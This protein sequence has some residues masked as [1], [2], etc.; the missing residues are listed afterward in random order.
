MEHTIRRYDAHMHSLSKQV[1]QMWN[2]YESE[3]V[4]YSNNPDHKSVIGGLDKENNSLWE[5]IGRASPF[6]YVRDKVKKDNIHIRCKRLIF[7]DFFQYH[8]YVEEF[9]EGKIV[10][11]Q[12]QETTDKKFSQYVREHDMMKHEL[13]KY[14][15]FL[16]SQSENKKSLIASDFDLPA[17]VVGS[18]DKANDFKWKY[19]NRVSPFL[20]V[21]KKIMNETKY[22]VTS[23]FM[24]KRKGDSRDIKVFEVS[25]EKQKQDEPC[26]N[27][28]QN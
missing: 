15:R 7:P 1:K 4:Y 17:R 18:L 19:I 14:V 12:H 24:G 22:H 20:I 27:Q 25:V 23:K 11:E 2:N 16:I 5:S 26:Q 8:L 21:R 9:D 28:S 10:P 3:R 6:E 13:E